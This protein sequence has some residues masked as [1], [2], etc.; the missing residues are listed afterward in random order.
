M[1]MVPEAANMPPNTVAH[2]DLGAGVLGRGGAAHPARALLPRIH[3]V[4]AGMDIGEA[5]AIVL[6]SRL[7][8]GAVLCSAMKAPAPPRGN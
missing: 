7:P 5:A 6:S 8:P 4:H 3:V 2:R 1:M